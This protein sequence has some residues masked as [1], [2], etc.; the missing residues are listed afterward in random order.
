MHKDRKLI[1]VD[2]KAIILD[3]IFLGAKTF[4]RD[5]YKKAMQPGDKHMVTKEESGEG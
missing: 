5:S 2:T 3:N 4:T 1:K